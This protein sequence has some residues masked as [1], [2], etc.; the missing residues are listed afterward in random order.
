[1]EAAPPSTS[2][3]ENLFRA[4]LLFSLSNKI[5]SHPNRRPSFLASFHNMAS[6]TTSSIESLLLQ[7]D[8]ANPPGREEKPS[9]PPQTE[10]PSVGRRIRRWWNGA[11]REA[12]AD[13]KAVRWRRLPLLLLFLLWPLA[14]LAAT[15]VVP[16]LPVLVGA[17]GSACRPD[18]SF[19]RTRAGA[20][21]RFPASFK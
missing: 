11:R 7:P 2:P 4:S 16:V 6:L 18:G 1:M 9:A 17:T 3:R 20:S 13:L 15:G 10:R 8:K 5:V 19:S 12:W 21:G 14:L